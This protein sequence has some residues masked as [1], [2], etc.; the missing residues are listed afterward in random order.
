MTREEKLARMDELRAEFY[1][2]KAEVQDEIESGFTGDVLEKFWARY[3]T[4]DIGSIQRIT[5]P[6]HA[7]FEPDFASL[8][9]FVMRNRLFGFAP[10]LEVREPPQ[11]VDD[12]FGNAPVVDYDKRLAEALKI[13]DQLLAQNQEQRSQI[14]DAVVSE[15]PMAQR[16]ED[17]AVVKAEHEKRKQEA[18]KLTESSRLSDQGRTEAENQ[19]KRS[20]A[21]VQATTVSVPQADLSE[22]QQR[23]SRET[24]DIQA[25]QAEAARIR[26]QH[27]AQ[28]EEARR[29]VE[30]H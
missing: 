13:R 6:G 30:G 1:K 8:L 10:N 21:S 2:L 27:L 25:R 16:L 5:A 29:R 19:R 24:A 17:L 28:A 11:P 3:R 23:I 9:A 15:S 20:F 22:E 4:M 18:L 12:A 26:D 14:D 7:D